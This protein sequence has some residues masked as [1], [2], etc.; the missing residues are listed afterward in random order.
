MSTTQPETRTD[1]QLSRNPCRLPR[2]WELTCRFW[3]LI[4]GPKRPAGW[5]YRS[6]AEFSRWR[7]ST[8]CPPARQPTAAQQAALIADIDR[9]TEETRQLRVR[10]LRCGVDLDAEQT[11]KGWSP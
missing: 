8:G 7:R 3:E 10:G 1:G 2:L 9:L 11:K 5:P 6:S 4:R